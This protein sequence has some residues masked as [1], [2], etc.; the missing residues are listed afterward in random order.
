MFYAQGVNYTMA[1]ITDRV[2][3]F[4]PEFQQRATLFIR[5]MFT[6]EDDTLRTVRQNIIDRGLPVINIRAEEG[7]MLLF[8]ARLCGARRMLEIGTLAGYSGIWLAR[9][10][11]EGGTLITLEMDPR[12]AQIAREHFALAG[13]ADRIQLIE[14]EAMHT[15]NTT[16]A[17]ADPFDMVFI[18]ADKDG[19]PDYYEWA[20]TH[21]RPGGLI[22][23]HNAFR[24][25]YLFADDPKAN[26]TRAMLKQM[27]NDPR[28]T[29][30]I[31]PVGDG[32]AAAVVK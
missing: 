26:P 8:L 9:A 17:G 11:P 18:D 1:S 21:T 16:L 12:H 28:V 15:L 13:V 32:F 24:S 22:T 30:T 31:V 4:T 10:L 23:A 14:G 20:V 25:G 6:P 19:Y 3:T 7:H 2:L 29:S 27:A 5:E